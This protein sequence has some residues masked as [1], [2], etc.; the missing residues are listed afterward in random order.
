MSSKGS[1]SA[2]M[3]HMLLLMTIIT[4]ICVLSPIEITPLIIMLLVSTISSI[5]LYYVLEIPI[6]E[7]D[8]M[9]ELHILS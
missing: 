1:L 2:A 7:C 3:I 9:L 8:K 5:T 6:E 4:I